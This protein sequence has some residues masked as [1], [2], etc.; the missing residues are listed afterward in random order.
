MFIPNPPDP[1]QTQQQRRKSGR[2]FCA[3]TKCQFGS[4]EDLS[5][6]GCR[7][8]SK[9]R[10][11]IPPGKSVNIQFTAPGLSLVVPARLVVCR[12]REDGKYDLGFQFIGLTQEGV[13]EVINF[14][15]AAADNEALN[16]RR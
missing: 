7:I 2:I 9:Q 16:A 6:E 5:R 15:R 1:D 3:Q 13:R 4:V 8:A 12:P 10:L 11:E 14:A